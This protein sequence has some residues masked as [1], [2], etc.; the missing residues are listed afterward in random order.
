MKLDIAY[1][2]DADSYYYFCWLYFSR[3]VLCFTGSIGA[4]LLTASMSRTNNNTS[5]CSYHRSICH[6]YDEH[7]TKK[8]YI[9]LV[10]SRARRRPIN[11]SHSFTKKY[12]SE[13]VSTRPFKEGWYQEELGLL[14][15]EHGP[16]W[17]D[18]HVGPVMAAPVHCNRCAEDVEPLTS[19]L[20]KSIDRLSCYNCTWKC[21]PK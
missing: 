21:C 2:M 18:S 20:F 19:G 13:A 10:A 1:N 5:W 16:F 8:T 17:P 7:A 6:G 11:D 9:S 14:R 12:F 3:N 4:I 15:S